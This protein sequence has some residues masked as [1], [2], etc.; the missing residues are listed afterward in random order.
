[1]SARRGLGLAL[2]GAALAVSIVG[3]ARMERSA[4]A[5]VERA[6]YAA[7]IDGAVFERPQAKLEISSPPL[8]VAVVEV[9]SGGLLSPDDLL[10]RLTRPEVKLLILGERHD[11]AQH[12]EIQAWLVEALNQTKMRRRALPL[13]AV[14]GVGGIAFEMIAEERE[15]LVNRRR[16]WPT[17]LAPRRRAATMEQIGE[18]ISWNETGWPDWSMYAPILLAAPQAYIAGGAITRE[19]F[20]TLLEPGRPLSLALP[21]TTPDRD[22]YRL[23]DALAP[24]EQALREQLQADAHCGMLPPEALPKIVAAQRARDASF[25]AAAIRARTRGLG[26]TVLIAG[27]GH[28]RADWGVPRF[29]KRVK[30]RLGVTSVAMVEVDP[31]LL[32]IARPNLV[33]RRRRRLDPRRVMREIAARYGVERPPFD[34]LVLTKPGDPGRVLGDPCAEMRAA[35]AKKG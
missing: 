23:D 17:G 9:A 32:E 35:M 14:Q 18:L 8:D 27:A 25:A 1:M 6:K 19:Q 15:L 4:N 12:H 34:Y 3:C 28:A 21:P 24:K 31:S 13:D 29:L 30:P 16:L 5:V 10:A 2:L 26:F 22:V 11:N 7:E 33:E 20:G